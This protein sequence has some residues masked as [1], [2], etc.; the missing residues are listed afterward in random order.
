MAKKTKTTTKAKK[1]T[2]KKIRKAPAKKS[3]TK[4]QAECV[5]FNATNPLGAWVVVEK[6]DGKQ[7]K[8]QT[9][10]PAKVVSGVASVWL[11]DVS[12]SVPISVLNPCKRGAVI[13]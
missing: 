11:E 5:K 6:S 3:L 7:F 4:A 9:R 12:G 2:A 8:T 10:S 13:K 1:T